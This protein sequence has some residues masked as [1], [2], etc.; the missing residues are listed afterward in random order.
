[1]EERG[2]REKARHGDL[3]QSELAGTG[4]TARHEESKNRGQDTED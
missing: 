4:Q 3:G 2:D 1:M